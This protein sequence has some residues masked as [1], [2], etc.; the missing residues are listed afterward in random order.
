MRPGNPTDATRFVTPCRSNLGSLTRL[1][2]TG[3]KWPST[4]LPR[5]VIA[6]PVR[7]ESARLDAC[8][9][10]LAAA[11]HEVLRPH[12]IILLFNGC[13]DE[14]W[15]TAARWALRAPLPVLMAET[16]LPVTCNHAGGARAAVLTLA[17]RTWAS[18]CDARIFTSDADTRV[19]T[20]WLIRGHAALDSGA[21]AVAGAIMVDTPEEWPRALRQ[22]HML[23]SAYAQMLD[24]IDVLC[25][26]LPHNPWPTHGQCPGA[27]LA[28]QS[29]ALRR[30]RVIPAPASGEDR[31]LI[32]ACTALD[33]RIR[34]D[35]DFRVVTSARMKGR[36]VGGMADALYRKA[37]FRDEPCDSTLEALQQHILRATTRADARRR[38]LS[39]MSAQRMARQICL[40][41]NSTSGKRFRYFGAL[42]QHLEAGA[43]ALARVPMNPGQLPS[44]MTQ[45]R[46]WLRRRASA[47]C[48]RV[49]V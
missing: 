22:R 35:P 10:A 30:L 39:G 24:E 25:D 2:L 12:G 3:S 21:D 9:D 16:R 32:A 1:R 31:A 27:S 14:S 47:E 19:A 36:A 34:H 29:S 40:P 4:D 6:I 37:Y 8:L 41:L 11:Q 49:T 15:P 28:F 20:D 46:L 42:W 48:G 33:L 18:E 7:N 38:F 26:P 5:S 44:Q 13:N 17:L 43:P 23:E 45:A